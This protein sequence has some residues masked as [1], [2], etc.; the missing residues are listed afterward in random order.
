MKPLK[1]PK[2]EL[3][4]I[5]SLIDSIKRLKENL[6]KDK[7]SWQ[8]R[9][10]RRLQMEINMGKLKKKLDSVTDRIHAVEQKLLHSE[11]TSKN[12]DQ[13][14]TDEAQ[15]ET[16]NGTGKDQKEAGSPKKNKGKLESRQKAVETESRVKERD[17]CL[18]DAAHYE[19]KNRPGEDQKQ[20]RSP[21][22]KK[23]RFEYQPKLVERT[24]DSEIKEFDQ[25]LTD[26]AHQETKNSPGEDH[27]DLGLAKQ[28]KV[29]FEYLQKSA[30]ADN[31]INVK[32]HDQ[33]KLT[34]KAH[35]ETKNGPGED[36]KDFRFLK[37]NKR[38]YE[39]KQKSAEQTITDNESNIK[40]HDHK[41]TNE[42]HQETKNGPGEDQKDLGLSK[43]KKVRFEY[44]QKGGEHTI[45]D[46]ESR[47]KERDQKLTD[48][49]HQE[50]KNGPGEDQKDLGLFKHKKVRFEYQ[51]KGVE[52]TI[53]DSESNIKESDQKLPDKAHQEIKNGPREDQKDRLLKENKGRPEWKQKSEQTI[54]DSENHIKEYDQKLTDEAHQE[55]KTVPGEDQKDLGLPK[56]KKGRFEYRQKAVE[57]TVVDSENRSKTYDQNLTD[58]NNK[59]PSNKMIGHFVLQGKQIF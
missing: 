42:A 18:T 9:K 28:K 10:K 1:K 50:T 3:E 43:H 51:Q 25:K 40:E 47:G 34:D 14:F 49:A 27:K 36:Q 6:K 17:S 7:I 8:D 30:I 39:Y 23:V 4:K 16:I 13:S 35:Q 12:S 15:Q 48:E 21:K 26:K 53:V 37:E 54:A 59:Q 58:F 31:E 52:H 55:T 45:V 56:E 11:K 44:R 33:K 2:M 22:E 29:R 20:P 41:L 57:Q 19:T 24:V 32:E 5:G 38:R 46:S